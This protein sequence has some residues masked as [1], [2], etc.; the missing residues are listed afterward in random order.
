MEITNKK[1]NYLFDKY[2][3]LIEYEVLNGKILK[4][5]LKIIRYINA[6]NSD[7]IVSTETA[8]FQ[9]EVVFHD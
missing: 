6:G 5:V 3:K 1:I 2:D 9:T 8:Y 7:S 4:T